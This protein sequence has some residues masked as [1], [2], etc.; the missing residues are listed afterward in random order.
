MKWGLEVNSKEGDKPGPYINT[1]VAWQGGENA[2]CSRPR[3]SPESA[4]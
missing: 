2:Y 3:N 1:S 4:N